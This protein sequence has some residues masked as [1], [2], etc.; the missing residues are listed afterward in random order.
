M[1][2]PSPSP[3]DKYPESSFEIGGA[4]VAQT[5]H[6]VD[7]RRDFE[8]TDQAHRDVH[9]RWS[10]GYYRTVTRAVR[11]PVQDSRGPIVGAVGKVQ[12]LLTPGQVDDLVEA[13]RAG[14]STA[15]LS[16][17]F[18]IHRR[19]A[20]AHLRRQAALRPRGLAPE[21]VDQAVRLYES[22]ESLAQIGEQFGTSAKTVRRVLLSLGVQMRAPWDRPQRTM[23]ST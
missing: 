8:N 1:V 22:G 14:A 18:K 23:G 21:H 10:K 2:I 7:L 5:P 13:Y 17:R 6:L 4:D 19:T 9:L 3:C 16:E 20:I 15:E 11:P 12:T